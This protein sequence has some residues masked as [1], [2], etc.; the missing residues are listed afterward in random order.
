MSFLPLMRKREFFL[1]FMRVESPELKNLS[2]YNH[3]ALGLMLTD[4]VMLIIEPAL[5][6]A[7]MNLCYVKD[8]VLRVAMNPREALVMNVKRNRKQKLFKEDF[9][10]CATMVQYLCGIDLKAK[11]VNT[12][13]KRLTTKDEIYL[14][15]HGILGVRPWELKQ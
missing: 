9:Q 14:R 2:G 5:E 13:Y 10:T 7:N 11:L 15:R 3:M 6:G 12:L 1:F 4:E 8:I